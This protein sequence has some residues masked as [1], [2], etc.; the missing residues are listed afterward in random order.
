MIEEV[1]WSAGRLNYGSPNKEAYVET[2]GQSVRL[3]RVRVGGWGLY[4]SGLWDRLT[5][6]SGGGKIVQKSLKC[7]AVY[8]YRGRTGRNG[9]SQ[10]GRMSGMEIKKQPPG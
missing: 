8:I 10:R 2:T 5:T 3:R 6:N 1:G 4:T 9:Y 7:E